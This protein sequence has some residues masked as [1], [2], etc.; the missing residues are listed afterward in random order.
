[1]V[2]ECSRYNRPS[3]VCMAA[4][5]V[6]SVIVRLSAR[7]C[8]VCLV[9]IRIDLINMTGVADEV[10]C[11]E[12]VGRCIGVIC[13]TKRSGLCLKYYVIAVYY[14]SYVAEVWINA[15]VYLRVHRVVTLYT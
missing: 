14:G 10:G 2:P 4:S 6:Q 9:M 11:Y 7:R 5:A 12:S 13:K 8:T 15:D 1:M 3:L